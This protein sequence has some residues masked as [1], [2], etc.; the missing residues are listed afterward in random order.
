MTI[1]LFSSCWYEFCS[2]ISLSAASR[3]ECKLS[4][5]MDSGCKG[6][7]NQNCCFSMHTHIQG[8]WMP[9]SFPESFVIPQRALIDGMQ[10]VCTR[11]GGDTFVD[12]GLKRFS[13]EGMLLYVEWQPRAD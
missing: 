10:T 11:L 6:Q 9:L 13:I 12:G 8:R 7:T 5:P 2:A 4:R 1:F 3:Q